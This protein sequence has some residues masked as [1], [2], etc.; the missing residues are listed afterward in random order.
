MIMK[1]SCKE[2]EEDVIK[3]KQMQ[4]KNV[5]KGIVDENPTLHQ[6]DLIFHLKSKKIA[7]LTDFILFIPD[8]S[9]LL[10]IY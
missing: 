1:R 5:L 6:N 2:D 8:H 9:I 3:K 7:L 10:F 4:V